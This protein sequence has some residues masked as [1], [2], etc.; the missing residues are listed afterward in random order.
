MAAI[1]LYV[2]DTLA[3]WECGH[4]LAEL[5][6]G[7]FLKDP[8]FG[9]DL[10]LCGRTMDPVTTMGGLSMVPKVLFRDIRPVTGDLV[11]LP[12]AD[13]WLDPIQ[14]PIIEMVRMLLDEGVVV[15]AICGATM[16]LANAGLLDKRPHTSNDLTVL[17]MFCP[18]YHGEQ[19]Y[20]NDPAVTDGNLITAGSLAP[21]EFAT[22]IFRRLDVM[23]PATLTAW[24]ALFTTRKPECFNALMASLPKGFKNP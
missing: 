20:V 23:S 8:A 13:T 17:K 15:A 22:H 2:T 4:V 12:G 21:V 3:D 24:H 1:Y 10:V 9:Y 6:S 16:A 7:R 11:L 19:F 14:G 5:H 18:D